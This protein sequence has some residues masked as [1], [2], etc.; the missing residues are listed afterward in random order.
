MSAGKRP[1]YRG[2]GN[3][4][5]EYGVPIKK[6]DTTKKKRWS[7]PSGAGSKSVLY[8]FLVVCILG[9][10]AWLGWFMTSNT[11]IKEVQVHGVSM[12]NPEVV[13]KSANVPTGVS[14]DSI[15]FLA[16]IEKVESISYVEQ[17]SVYVSPTGRLD[18]NVI[19]RN[20]I[21]ILVQGD[22]MVL[23]DRFGVKM[24]LP[25]KGVPN[26]PLLYGF[27]ILPMN[28]PVSGEGFKH[29]VAFLN[30]LSKEF[31]RD[32]TISEVAWH[33]KDGVIALT[34]SHGV[35]LTFGKG[36]YD[37]KLIKWQEFYRN[38]VPVRGLSSFTSLD[39]RFR[40]QIVAIE[41]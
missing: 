5:V 37:E 14:K 39:F 28:A 22:R 2:L 27:N 36:N 30:E 3:T 29:T 32:F 13:L 26:L 9:T 18:I 19:E 7:K 33:Q 11:T 12:L 25:E 21:A 15:N 8:L 10:S 35:R 16:V 41:S 34:R 1:Y 23:V 17:A 40:N 24:P 6:K 38:E 31:I 20:P 4:D